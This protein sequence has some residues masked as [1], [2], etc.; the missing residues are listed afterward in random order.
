MCS[1]CLL[2]IIDVE[3]QIVSP[4]G[5]S[6]IPPKRTSIGLLALVLA[7]IEAN[8]HE[9]HLKRSSPLYSALLCGAEHAP[10]MDVRLKQELYKSVKSDRAL[11]RVE[12]LVF[13]N[14]N[15]GDGVRALS[16]TT[17]AIDLIQ[18][19][20]KV[21]ALPELATAVV[22][23]RIAIERFGSYLFT[24]TICVDPLFLNIPAL[25]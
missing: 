7:E 9:A 5:H 3:I 13:N 2:Y 19:G 10:K 1:P 12:E 25:S 11:K 15:I 8:P 6:S 16:T 4:G 20:V 17:Q 24:T 23:H 22:N 18:G 14:P 21:N